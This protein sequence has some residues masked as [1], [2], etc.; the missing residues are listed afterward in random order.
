MKAREE[1]DKRR[2]LKAE[3]IVS[4]KHSMLLETSHASLTNLHSTVVTRR[5]NADREIGVNSFA[6]LNQTVVNRDKSPMRKSLLRDHSS[7]TYLR[8]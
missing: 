8:N 4:R 1:A 2:K 3:L 5:A 7:P 6:G